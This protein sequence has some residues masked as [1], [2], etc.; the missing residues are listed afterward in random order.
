MMW[1]VRNHRERGEG[2]RK[3]E[4]RKDRGAKEATKSLLCVVC[5]LAAASKA[6]E[7]LT[8]RKHGRDFCHQ[9]YFCSTCVI[10]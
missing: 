2:M 9:T 1:A 5:F 10:F 3:R 8:L 4:Q 7:S 6:L